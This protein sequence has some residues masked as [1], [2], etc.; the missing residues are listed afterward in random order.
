MMCAGSR[1][2]SGS[3]VSAAAANPA[4]IENTRNPANDFMALF[5]FGNINPLQILDLPA[6][7]IL[8]TDQCISFGTEGLTRQCGWRRAIGTCG[9]GSCPD[10]NGVTINCDQYNGFSPSHTFRTVS[11]G[12]TTAQC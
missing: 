4:V 5:A 7:A 8:V 11:E 1:A 10:H 2:M 12:G 6:F 3:A 9:R